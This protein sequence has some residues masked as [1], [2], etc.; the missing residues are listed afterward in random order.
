MGA[1]EATAFALLPVVAGRDRLPAALGLPRHGLGDHDALGVGAAGAAP[2][3][4]PA[5]AAG[6]DAGDARADP[7][8][9]CGLG[10][11]HTAGAVLALVLLVVPAGLPPRPLPDPGRRRRR[12]PARR[13]RPSTSS[14]PAAPWAC[15]AR[16]SPNDARHQG[17]AHPLPRDLGRRLRRVLPGQPRSASTGWPRASARRSRGRGSPA[18]PLLTA[19]GV[20]FCRTRVLPRAAGG[21]GGRALVALLTVLAPLGDL[22]ESLFKRDAGVK[23]SSDLIPGH[24]GF[25]DRT[26][27]LLLRRPVRAGAHAPARGLR[28]KRL[29]I[30]GSTGSIGTA[31]LDVVARFPEKF[32]VGGAGRRPQPRSSSTTQIRDLQPAPGRGRRRGRRRQRCAGRSPGLEVLAGAAGRDAVATHPDATTVVAAF[33]G[34]LGLVPTWRALALGRE[35]ALANKETL[36][37]AG[38][39]VMAAARAR[40]AA[41][42]LPI[43][44]EHNALHQALRVGPP[45]SGAPPDP[46]RLRGAVPHLHEGSSSRASPWR[47]RSPTRPGAMG[48]KIT[49][50][51]ATMMNKGLEIIEAHHLFGVPEERI[52]VVVHPESRVHSLVEYDDGTLIAQLSVNDMRFPIL[53]ALAYPERLPSPFGFL[54][55]VERRRAPLRGGRRGA[56]PLPAPGPRGAAR[57]RHGPRGPQRRQRGRGRGV[58]RRTAAVH[59]HRRPSSRP[60]SAREAAAG[61]RARARSTTS[62]RPTSAARAWAT[63]TDREIRPRPP[64]VPCENADGPCS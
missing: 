13:S 55:L 47:R 17:R 39:L 14:S 10:G 19:F 18:A 22:V 27:S 9:R 2:P 37:V 6:A 24:G 49:I 28:L 21:H 46:H 54:D 42:I 40:A 51:S 58:P 25:L 61:A 1:R 44:S 23:D 57:R 8:R 34:A 15:C 63:R 50:D 32:A 60:R 35:V 33:V 53:Y 3:P 31:T 7:A 5:R 26:D 52:A 64:Q 59:G 20:W 41:P 43:D 36:V 30:L 48:A 16:R 11:L 12:S 45:G 4:R 38:E 56:L 62:W 29:A